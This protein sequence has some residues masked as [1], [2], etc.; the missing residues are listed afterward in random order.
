[1]RTFPLAPICPPAEQAQEPL[2]P[3][4]IGLTLWSR[5]PFSANVPHNLAVD[6]RSLVLSNRRP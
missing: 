6:F 3:L 2:L 5:T 1:M 4:A